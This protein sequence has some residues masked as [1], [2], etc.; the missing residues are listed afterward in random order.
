FNCNGIETCNAQIGCVS[1]SPVNCDDGVQCTFD[2]CQDPQGTCTHTPQNFLCDDGNACNGIETCTLPGCTGGTAGN[3]CDDGIACT[4]D[5][6]NQL[7]GQCVSIPNNDACPCGQ[8]CNP[9]AGGCGNFCN[10]KTCQGHVYACGDCL[11]NDGDCKIDDADSQCLGPCDNTED[12]LYGGIP[13][14]NNSP[15]KSDCYFDQDTGSG[16]DDCYW[17]HKCDPL[18]VP[19][20]YPPED[21]KC[22]YN[23][24]ANIPG[25]T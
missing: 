23:P 10:I 11:D 14:Q 24:N 12:S 25:Y 2:A 6:C 16:N 20:L 3:P 4:I 22:A 17:S 8:T 18:E 13:G 5:T 15:C 1:T 19:P 9:T 7:T 21:S